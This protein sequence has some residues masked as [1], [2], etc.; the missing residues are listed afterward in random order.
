MPVH[1]EHHVQ[2]ARILFEQLCPGE[3]FLPK[4]ASAAAADS[5]EVE[6]ED[7]TL[8]SAQAQA[9]RAAKMQSQVKTLEQEQDQEPEKNRNPER[10]QGQGQSHGTGAQSLYRIMSAEEWSAAKQCGAYKGN[11]LDSGDGFMHLS[12]ASQVSTTLGRF[13]AG[14]E[15][16][17]LLCVGT[18]VS[19]LG[20]LRWE[21]VHG[22]TFPHLYKHGSESGVPALA[23]TT[24]QAAHPLALDPETGCHDLS[25]LRL[26]E[27]RE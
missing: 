8:A 15:D 10:D 13:F 7:A 26:G 18:D 20:D 24:V 19:A 4:A 12:T 5:A 21:H 6:E 9:E 11:A 3:P 23:V 14:R 16:I 27:Q 22:D 17:V 1:S 25:A 2:A